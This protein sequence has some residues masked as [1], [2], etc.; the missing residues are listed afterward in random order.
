MKIGSIELDYFYHQY[1]NTGINERKIEV[2]LALKFLEIVQDNCTEIGCVIPYYKTDSKHK[3]IDLYDEHPKALNIDAL[4]YDY[5]GENCL[6]ISTIEHF[7]E[8][9]NDPQNVG[10]YFDKD[11]GYKGLIKII[12]KAN[13]YLIS[14]PLG[15][16]RNLEQSVQNSDLQFFILNRDRSNNWSVDNTRSFN[17]EYASPFLFA[18][19]ICV[20]TNIEE[21]YV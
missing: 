5:S 9:Y 21:F 8:I 7:G 19:A 16:N 11:L 13:K 3:V 14:F 10:K 15:L 2:P 4:T 6:S 20:I 17:Y 1:N 18:N 12:E